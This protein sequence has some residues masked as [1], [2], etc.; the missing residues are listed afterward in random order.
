L[1]PPS[2]DDDML[3][4]FPPIAWKNGTEGSLRVLERGYEDRELHELDNDMFPWFEKGDR[5]E[6]EVES[7]E[8]DDRDEVE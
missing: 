7:S 1:F 5:G 2:A 4:L 6:S 3:L 8:M